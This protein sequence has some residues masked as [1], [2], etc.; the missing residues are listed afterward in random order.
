M[1]YNT[2]RNFSIMN[3]YISWGILLFSVC[4]DLLYRLAHIIHI[5]TLCG[6]LFIISNLRYRIWVLETLRDLI[7]V[8]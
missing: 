6:R 2:I 1:F 7:K 5:M 8:T 3:L 4:D